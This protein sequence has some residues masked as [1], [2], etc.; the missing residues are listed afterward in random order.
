MFLLMLRW[1]AQGIA[2]AWT[3]S[4]W[5]LILPGFWYAGKPIDFGVGPVIAVTWRFVVAA[6][7]AGCVTVMIFGGLASFAQPTGL[8]DAVMRIAKISVLFS[9]LY[10]GAVIILYRGFAP[11]YQVVGLLG[12]MLPGRRTSKVGLPQSSAQAT[13]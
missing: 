8:I 9:A 1:G 2:V 4:F 11:L 5:A 13:T 6:F 3:V 10:L 7:A 12:E